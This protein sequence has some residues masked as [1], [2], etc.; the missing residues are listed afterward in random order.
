[1]LLLLL[2]PG[3]LLLVPLLPA[4]LLPALL[5]PALLLPAL[6]CCAILQIQIVLIFYCLS[7]IYLLYVVPCKTWPY[8]PLPC[9]A[10]V[11]FMQFL[12]QFFLLPCFLLLSL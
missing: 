9:T 6:L 4:L 12:C 8:G 11:A 3:P 2:A 5:L 10:Y 7:A 1:L